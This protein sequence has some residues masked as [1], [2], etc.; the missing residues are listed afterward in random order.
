MVMVK[1]QKMTGKLLETIIL[2]YFR[3]NTNFNWKGLS[4]STTFD[5]QYG[6]EVINFSRYY[7]QTRK[8][9]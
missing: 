3:F 7:I 8:V 4:F 2:I 1:S 5:G 6:A 9:E